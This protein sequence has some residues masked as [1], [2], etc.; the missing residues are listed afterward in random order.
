[1]A[2]WRRLR[3]NAW[4]PREGLRNPR[5]ASHSGMRQIGYCQ[6]HGR[7]TRDEARACQTANSAEP[8]RLSQQH[9]QRRGVEN[10]ISI[11]NLA[12]TDFNFRRVQPRYRSE[13]PSEQQA[14]QAKKREAQARD[15]GEGRSC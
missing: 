8:D 11:A 2:K 9:P 4:Q 3:T 14:L 13:G 5:R 10:A 15:A 6:I 12:I 7:G 1:M